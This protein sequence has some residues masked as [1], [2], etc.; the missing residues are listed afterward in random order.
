M[1][2]LFLHAN[3]IIFTRAKSLKMNVPTIK[4]AHYE[5]LYS[6]HLHVCTFNYS[7]YTHNYSYAFDRNNFI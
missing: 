3:N 1:H 5:I 6:V 7:A 4:V 2:T